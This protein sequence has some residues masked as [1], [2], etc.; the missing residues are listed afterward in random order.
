[1]RGQHRAPEWV[2]SPSHL[3]NQEYLTTLADLAGSLGGVDCSVSPSTEGWRTIRV[4][5]SARSRSVLFFE[6]DDRLVY[7]ESPRRAP[8]S[9]GA[10]AA[11]D[12]L[13]LASVLLQR[14]D[15]RQGHHLEPPHGTG[16]GG[17]RREGELVPD[18]R[19]GWPVEASYTAAGFVFHAEVVTR[20]AKY[21]GRESAS[22]RS[23]LFVPAESRGVISGM[24]D[25]P[26]R[27][28]VGWEREFAIGIHG[29]SELFAY[30]T[31]EI[32]PTGRQNVEWLWT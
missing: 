13:Q 17:S 27:E 15:V 19:E 22:W 29:A 32:E 26:D 28:T 2:A 25:L 23:D 6:H 18:G 31:S 12:A 11:P 10:V 4:E 3:L 16:L 14:Q 7:I 24:A 30:V 21:F 9:L 8:V 20:V 1:M 5:I